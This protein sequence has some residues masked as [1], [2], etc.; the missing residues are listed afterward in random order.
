[1]TL[2]SYCT[3]S[4]QQGKMRTEILILIRFAGRD[5]CG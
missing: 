2:Q 1:M 5:W 3:G 4:H